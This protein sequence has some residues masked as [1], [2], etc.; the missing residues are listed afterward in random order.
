MRG[1]IRGGPGIKCATLGN[2]IGRVLIAIN[3]HELDNDLSLGFPST[4]IVKDV[5][6]KLEF[7]VSHDGQ[8]EN[9]K[10]ITKYK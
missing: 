3:M 9:L 4:A 2:N 5:R 7:Y 10:V 6:L 8:I 1:L